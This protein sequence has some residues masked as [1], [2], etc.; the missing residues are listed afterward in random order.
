MPVKRQS[1]FGVDVSKFV[2]RAGDNIDQVNRKVALD[3][4]TDIVL[5][6]PVDTGRARGSWTIGGNALPTVYNKA[7]DKGGDK[8]I[9]RAAAKLERVKAGGSIFI[10]TNLEYMPPL[11]YVW[12]KQ[13]PSGMVR[14]AVRKFRR[15]MREAVREAKRNSR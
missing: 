12:S 8:T 3:M 6:T 10:A 14:I 2:E 7:K 4:L 1:S 5:N 13:S 11:E 15:F 9:K